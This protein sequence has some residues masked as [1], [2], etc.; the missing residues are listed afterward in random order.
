MTYS[1]MS[2]DHDFEY[3]TV[4]ARWGEFGNDFHLKRLIQQEKQ[5]G[6][7]MMEQF[8]NQSVRFCRPISARSRDHLLPPEIDPYR[9]QYR[10]TA[11]PNTEAVDMLLMAALVL[12]AIVVLLAIII[13][14]C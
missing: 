7:T 2:Y 10:Y 14:F 4:H 9:T 3:K 1:D 11:R 13:P 5:A 8:G 6:W 12:V